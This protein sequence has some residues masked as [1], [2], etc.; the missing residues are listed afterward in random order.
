MRAIARD[1]QVFEKLIWTCMNKDLQYK[2]YKLRKGQLLTEEAKEKR[3]KHCKK[4]LNK[5][6]HPLEPE[7]LFFFE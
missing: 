1:L 2:S 5:L 4:L 6:N 7:M 3:L